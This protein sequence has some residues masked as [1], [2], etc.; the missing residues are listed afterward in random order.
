MRTEKTKEI[1]EK[2]EDAS[3]WKSQVRLLSKQIQNVQKQIDTIDMQI[4]KKL[5]DRHAILTHCKVRN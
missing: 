4:E 1:K 3:N 5:A 2:E